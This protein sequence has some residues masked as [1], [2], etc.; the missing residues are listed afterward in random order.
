MQ[1][2]SSNGFTSIIKGILV[3]LITVLI[4]VLIFAGIVKLASLS[5]GVIQ[6]VNQLIKILAVFLGC[7]FTVR[8]GLGFLKGGIIGLVGTA[9]TYLVFSFIGGNVSF[10][11]SGLLDIF[12]GLI[13]GIISGIIAVNI[14]KD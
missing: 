12:F 3:T 7:M 10:G 14:K 1:I 8:G 11:V 4:G 6:A 5:S 13:I 2:K 9:L